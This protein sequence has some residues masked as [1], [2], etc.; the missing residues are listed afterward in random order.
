MHTHSGFATSSPREKQKCISVGTEAY[1]YNYAREFLKGPVLSP[2][3]FQLYI[4]HLRR[5]IPEYVDAAM[6]ADDDALF[7]SRPD[8]HR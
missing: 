4:V 3:L 5:L 8:R 1:R 7:S 2:L 6:F